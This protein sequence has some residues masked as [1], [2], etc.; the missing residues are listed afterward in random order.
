MNRRRDERGS[1]TVEAV[2]GIPVVI[3]FVSFT[4]LGGRL[5]IARQ[6]VES[7]AADAARSA[8][9]ARTQSTAQAQGQAAG[10]AGLA[11]QGLA[12]APATVTLDT[13]QFS[14]PVGTP[15]VVVATVT[16][17]VP[18]YDLG[19]PG[20]SGTLRVEAAQTSPLDTYRER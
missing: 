20:I 5:A 18:T 11:N 10:H 8:S 17:A 15:A 6:A 7:A 13:S 4:I 3:L 14:R 9:I 2:L 12:C 1:A 19:I 16:C